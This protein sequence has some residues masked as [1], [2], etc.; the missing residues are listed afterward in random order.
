MSWN[1]DARLQD[2]TSPTAGHNER[3]TCHPIKVLNTLKNY[4]VFLFITVNGIGVSCASLQNVF[5]QVQP[6][7]SVIKE[8]DDGDNFYVIERY[9]LRP[10]G[11]HQTS[12]YAFIS[13]YQNFIIN[14]KVVGFLSEAN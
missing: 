8:G 6:G 7:D 5:Q 9:I 2:S 4:E 14:M 11:P 12:V 13:K 3:K 10:S 1:S